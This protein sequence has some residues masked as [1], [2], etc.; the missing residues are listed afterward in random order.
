MAH[1]YDEGPTGW[2]RYVEDPGKTKQTFT[3]TTPTQQFKGHPY[4]KA[5]DDTGRGYPYLGTVIGVIHDGPLHET[6]EGVGAVDVVERTE[7]SVLIEIQRKYA[8]HLD[9][10]HPIALPKETEVT[11][12]R[13]VPSRDEY[14]IGMLP[15][16]AARSKDPRTAVGAVIVGWAKNILS[17]GYNGFPTGVREDSDRWARENKENFVCHAEINAIINA[18][19][20]GTPIDNATLYVSFLPCNACCKAI[21]NA[22]I[23]RVVVDH[24][25]QMM[26]ASAKSEAYREL[27]ETMFEETGVSLDW[28]E[29]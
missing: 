16:I 9:T 3:F 8:E 25:F 5:V 28:F 13:E 10:L 20:V 14:F 29:A 1:H 6:A 27:T 4:W 7:D 24:N 18:A 26:K 17:T 11:G 23:I 12:P 22:G 15:A 2:D 19:R 21:I